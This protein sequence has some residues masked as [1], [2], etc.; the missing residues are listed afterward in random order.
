MI[1]KKL[2][3][4]LLLGGLLLAPS[5]IAAQT[6]R[7]GVEGGYFMP[8]EQIF[9]DVY[10]SGGVCYG[11]NITFFVTSKISLE[12]G[13]NSYNQEGTVTN[14]TGK[15]TLG[16]QTIRLGGFYHFGNG[17]L[18]PRIGAGGIYSFV[19]EETPY[20]DFD[21]SGAGWFAGAGV[22]LQLSGSLYL[23]LEGLY[24]DTKI[25]GDFGEVSIGGIVLLVNFKIGI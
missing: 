21:D 1:L 12:A 23:G 8:S 7:I 15:T 17:K 18:V 20:G 6:V 14:S 9:K 16:I 4:I 2:L 3:M 19:S 25:T 13:F 10:G 22:D 11:G 5:F 24:Q